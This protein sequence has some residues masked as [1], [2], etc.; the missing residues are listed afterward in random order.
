MN[1]DIKKLTPELAE[2]YACFFDTTTHWGSA[3]TKCYCITWC[4]DDIYL[5]GGSHWFS[6]PE[7]RRRNAIQRVRDGNIQGYLAYYDDKIV[8]WCNANTKADCKECVN[9]LRTDGGVPLEECRTGEKVKFIFCF[10][11]APAVQR[12]GVATKLLDYICRDAAADGYDYIEAYPNKI[13]TEASRDYKG[14]LAMY[15]KCGFTVHAEKEGNVVVRK[16]LK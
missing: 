10:A 14:P 2:E 8:G 12:M 5:N 4:N 3:D 13:I 1:I 16:V 9:Y 7:E 15:E 6:S 11:I